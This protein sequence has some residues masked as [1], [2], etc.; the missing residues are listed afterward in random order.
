MKKLKQIENRSTKRNSLK[1]FPRYT[2]QKEIKIFKFFLTA[3][4]PGN[5]FNEQAIESLHYSLLYWN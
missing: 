5:G 1:R 2:L 3:K 4:M